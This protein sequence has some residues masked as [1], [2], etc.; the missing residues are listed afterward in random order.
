MW[1]H[2]IFYAYFKSLKSSLVKLIGITFILEGNTTA[3]T[4]VVLDTQKKFAFCCNLNKCNDF[5]FIVPP[6][7]NQN[8][9]YLQLD[10]TKFGP[11]TIILWF[12]SAQ[13]QK[14]N[15]ILP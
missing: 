15:F 3:E 6:M 5:N 1:V 8:L 7:K 4:A 9:M 13:H 14:V 12:V 11:D 2:N 10:D